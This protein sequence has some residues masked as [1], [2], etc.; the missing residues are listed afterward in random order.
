[1]STDNAN[2]ETRDSCDVGSAGKQTCACRKSKCVCRAFRL[3][4]VLI[5]LGGVGAYWMLFARVYRL[6]V[7]RSAMQK[8]ESNEELQRELGKPIKAVGWRPPNARL[9]EREQDVLWNIAGPK[10]H[11]K[12]HVF[13]R[14]MQGKWET[15]IM[16]VVLPNGKKMS[17]AEEGGAEAF[18]PSKAQTK[19]PEPIGPAPEI[20]LLVPPGDG[21]GKP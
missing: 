5:A 20:N 7:V 9:E 16:E 18:D 15:A 2:P 8:I 14:L 19:K 1:M 13:A 12:A 17:L 10:G 4:L 6:D 3:L 11:A 21:P